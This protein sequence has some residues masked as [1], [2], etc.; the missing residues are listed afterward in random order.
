MN[1]SDSS[2]DELESNEALENSFLELVVGSLNQLGTEDQK[3]VFAVALLEQL[4]IITQQLQGNN[5]AARSEYTLD[6][7]STSIAALQRSL[8]IRATILVP[9]LPLIKK[10]KKACKQEEMCKMLLVLL[11]KPAV[12]ADE[13]LFEYLLTILDTLLNETNNQEEISKQRAFYEK[14][15]VCNFL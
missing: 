2:V 4:E 6:L 15:Q 10:Q 14:L 1:D 8:F 9:L 3:K 12:Q 13:D 5:T 11:S 7:S